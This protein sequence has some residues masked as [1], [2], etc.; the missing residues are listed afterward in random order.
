MKDPRLC[1][2]H[3]RSISPT[4]P[5]VW[6]ESAVDCFQSSFTLFLRSLLALLGSP[7]RGPT[8]APASLSFAARR[9]RSP[10]PLRARFPPPS[11]HLLNEKRGTRPLFRSM[12]EVAG[13]EPASESI[14]SGL[15]P[16][17]ASD[18]LIRLGNRPEAGYC[19]SYPVSP[20]CCRAFT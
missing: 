8:S 9:V 17:A 5:P 14:S 1:M 3:I 11:P 7:G 20:L 10:N 15:S 19:L 16:S 4:Y 2:S 12:V 13:I 6:R 18:L